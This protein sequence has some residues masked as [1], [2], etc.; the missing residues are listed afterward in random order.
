MTTSSKRPEQVAWASLVASVI[1]F[2]VAFFLGRWSGYAAVSAVAWQIL[3]AALIWLVLAIQFHQRNLAEQERL[4]MTGLGEDSRQSTIFQEQGE[5]ASLMAAAQRRLE[6]IEKWVVPGMAVAIAAYEIV[7]GILVVRGTAATSTDETQQPLVCSIVMT[8]VAFV[9]FLLSRYAT[10]MSAEPH[11]KPL[12]AGGSFLLGI[13][14]VC[15]ALAIALAAIHFQRY[16]AVRVIAYAIPILLIILGVETAL[17]AVLDIY[18]PRLKGQ[19]SRAAFDSRLLGIINEPGGV[20]RSAAAAID[21]QFGFEVSQTWF[22]KL[23]EK[24]IVPLVLFSALTLYL[25]SCILVV[26]PEEQAIVERFGNP[27]DAQGQP[28]LLGPGIHFKMPWPIDV[29]HKVPTQKVNEIYIGYVPQRDTTTGAAVP[30]AYLLWGQN[31]YKEEQVFL[32][33]SEYGNEERGSGAP[34]VGL[35]NANVPVQYR[36]KDL[37][38]YLY[39]CSDPPRLLED[40]CY[41]ELTRFTAS[42]KVEPRDMA[43]VNE[44]DSLFGRGRDRAKRVLFQRI[45]QAAD[46][47]QLGVE[48]V[49]VGMQGIHPPVAVAKDYQAVIGAI[50]KQQTLILKEEGERNRKLSKLAGTVSRAYDLADMAE[51]YQAAQAQNDRTRIEQLG[52]QLDEA[53]GAAKGEIFGILADAQSYAFAKAALA[54]ADG[55]RFASQLKAYRAAPHIYPTQ[56]K[57]SVLEEA[58]SGTRK[59]VVDADPNDLQ[60]TTINLEEIPGTNLLDV[61]GSPE[62]SGQ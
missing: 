3:A 25:A 13:A 49:F 29:A 39:H 53:F 37:Y 33:A 11:W 50:Q 10:G 22:Y 55:E 26:N 9:T 54:K 31:H 40:I 45:Q 62:S 34:P 41:E 46:A 21:Y 4:D 5:R 15:F 42:S 20:F 28:H 27:L 61:I 7:V 43:A 24:A 44:D 17:N 36:I 14:V 47:R 2:G 51:A 57:L 60:V 12:R 6:V 18:R 38:A 1:F 52:S 8:A 56:Q 23:L 58:L 48:I 30:E 59:Y 35:V 32:V 19:Y 16:L